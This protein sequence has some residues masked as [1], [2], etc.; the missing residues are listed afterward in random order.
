[1]ENE[2]L[3][4][5]LLTPGSVWLRNRKGETIQNQVLLLSN[6]HLSEKMQAAYPPEVVFLDEEGNVTTMPIARFLETRKFHNVNPQLEVAVDTMLTAAFEDDESEGDEDDEELNDLSPV[7]AI[8]SEI[9]A[10]GAYVSS[11]KLVT[12]SNVGLSPAGAAVAE[13]LS[14][15][16]CQYSQAPMP[17]SGITAHV[18][19]FDNN[20]LSLLGLTYKDISNLFTP[21]GTDVVQT[22]TVNGPSP[23]TVEWTSFIG[24]FPIMSLLKNRVALYVGT[25][26]DV[27]N[28]DAEIAA[29]EEGLTQQG[30]AGQAPTVDVQVVE[31][32]AP[33]ETVTVAVN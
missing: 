10:A 8:T 3:D 6:L 20:A 16:I 4:I 2:E 11:D 18:I 22:F 12:F 9:A 30:T 32:A 13:Q 23:T 25:D 26:A 7:E 1:M 27:S 19:E 5:S 14:S 17:S 21:D 28:I 33:A 29:L 15:C 24:V 31:G